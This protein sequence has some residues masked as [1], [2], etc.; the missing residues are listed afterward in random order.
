MRKVIFL[1]FLFISLVT[2]AQNSK[3]KVSLRNGTAIEGE[4]K[5]FD[6][7]DHITIIVGGVETTI[8]MS[9]VAYVSNIGEQGQRASETTAGNSQ[10]T[11]RIIEET[12]E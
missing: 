3:V 7:L 5:E 12:K 2:S 6:A 11:T 1:L 8:P 10:G 4:V 9:Q